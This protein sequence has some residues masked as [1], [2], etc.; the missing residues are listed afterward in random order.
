MGAY[1]FI[2]REMFLRGDSVLYCI[3]KEEN[4]KTKLLHYSL[5]INL[6]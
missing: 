6:I 1:F 3:G 5:H 4:V 2:K